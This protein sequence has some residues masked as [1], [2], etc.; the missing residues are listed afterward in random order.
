[1]KIFET[2]KLINYYRKIIRDFKRIFLPTKFIYYNHNN[3]INFAVK[4]YK[5]FFFKLYVDIYKER[6]DAYKT[7]QDCETKNY[8]QICC[9]AED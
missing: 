3:F 9:L 2:E 7:E 6:I 4:C 8:Q 5:L 1:M